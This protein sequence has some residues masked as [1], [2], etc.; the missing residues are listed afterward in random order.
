M[1]ESSRVLLCSFN[2]DLKLMNPLPGIKFEVQPGLQ[3][4]F[5]KQKSVSL[6]YKK[7]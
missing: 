5:Q 7:I 6:G 3:T 2:G 1:C 4:E